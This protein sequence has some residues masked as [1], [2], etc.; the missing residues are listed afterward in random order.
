MYP[1]TGCDPKFDAREPADPGCVCKMAKGELRT[2]RGEHHRRACPMYE[3]EAGASLDHCA[4]ECSGCETETG[5]CTCGCIGC[6]IGREYE[7]RART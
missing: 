7:R 4:D 3:V 2:D 1:D 6:D 5:W